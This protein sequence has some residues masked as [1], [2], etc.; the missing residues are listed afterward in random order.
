MSFGYFE[1]ICIVAPGMIVDCILG[2]DFLGK[3][4]VI[5][6]FEDQCMYTKDENG[7]I[8]HQFVSEEMSKAELKKE[9]PIGEIR[10]FYYRGRWK[11]IR[12][13]QWKKK[14]R[15]LWVLASEIAY[16]NHKFSLRDCDG[17]SIEQSRGYLQHTTVCTNLNTV[18]VRHQNYTGLGTSQKGWRS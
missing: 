7:S 2:A 9:V 10:N 5:I 1:H 8:Q 18:A 15:N 4:K 16:D 14:E 6:S 11:G 13:Q 12:L 3:C 17:D